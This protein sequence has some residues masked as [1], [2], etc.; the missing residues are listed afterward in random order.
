VASP[1]ASALLPGAGERGRGAAGDKP[2]RLMGSATAQK[3]TN[4]I[5]DTEIAANGARQPSGSPITFPKM[6]PDAANRAKS[7]S[8]VRT[9]WQGSA[10]AGLRTDADGDAHEEERQPACLLAR[11]RCVVDEGRRKR[12]ERR[13]AK[14]HL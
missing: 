10:A 8:G 5:M 11:R 13:L 4:G 14:A 9:F 12:A 3:T 6:K 7:R 1:S 2:R